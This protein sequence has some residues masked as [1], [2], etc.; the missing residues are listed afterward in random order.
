MPTPS[1]ASPQTVAMQNLQNRQ[2]LIQS[3]LYMV[4]KLP[5]ATVTAM[6]QSIR[7][8]LERIGITTGVLLEFTVPVTVTAAATQSPFGPYNLA[9]L[10]SYTDYAG[11]QRVLTSGYQLHALNA[12]RGQRFPD[13]ADRLGQYLTAAETGL[14]TNLLALPTATGSANINFSLFVPLAYDAASDLRGAVLSQTIYGD[15]Y[16]TV[17]LQNALVNADSFVAP[18]TAGTV[19]IQASGVISVQA[20]QQY[21]MPQQGVQNLPMVDLSTIY[22]VEGNYTDNSN[23][24]AGQSKFINWPNNRAVM[25]ALHIFDNGGAGV[26]NGADLSQI[27]LLGNSNTNI[28]EMLPSYLRRGMRY[29]LRSDL[30]SGVYYLSSRAQPITT[31]LYG[32]VQTRFDVATANANPYF[33][34]Q[35]ESTYLSGTPLPGIVQ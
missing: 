4:K 6:G 24:A 8:N 7:I 10:V 33:V 14:D 34:S 20:Y 19:A 11:L 26:A 9:Q 32:N 30:A 31:Q 2:N 22:A 5:A 12:F 28:R 29:Q 18:Y 13:N 1:A 15:H 27:I 21:I 16:V 35:Y 23:I 17:N 25:S 3:G